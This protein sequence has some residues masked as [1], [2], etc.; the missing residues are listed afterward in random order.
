M[1]FDDSISIQELADLPEISAIYAVISQ[2]KGI[3]Y[4]G[5]SKHLRSRWQGHHR[6]KQ[7]QIIDPTASLAWF[8][9]DIELLKQTEDALI[10]K[11]QPLLNGSPVLET[12]RVAPEKILQNTL[13]KMA[14]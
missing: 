8:A 7:V 9:C 12:K 5:K 4:I 13:V 6:L 14:P 10:Q 3:L 2:S 11:Y 1:H